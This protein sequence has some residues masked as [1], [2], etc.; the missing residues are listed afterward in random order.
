MTS[1]G[2]SRGFAL[3]AALRSLSVQTL[4][5]ADLKWHGDREIG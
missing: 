3:V 1:R 5:K 2:L 4:C